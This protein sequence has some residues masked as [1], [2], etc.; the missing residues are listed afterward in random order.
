MKSTHS[1]WGRSIIVLLEHK[2]WVFPFHFD[3]K[4]QIVVSPPPPPPKRKKRKN[5]KPQQSNGTFQV[6][7]VREKIEN[8]P[9]LTNPSA[10]K[11]SLL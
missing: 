4:H 8:F 9:I 1:G 6:F 7:K 2:F 5:G 3:L 10:S 11:I